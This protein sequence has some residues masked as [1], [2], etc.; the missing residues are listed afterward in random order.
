MNL[1]TLDFETYFD[2]DYTLSK[3]TTEAYVRDPRF[4]VHCVGMQGEYVPGEII[5]YSPQHINRHLTDI[6]GKFSDNALLCHHAQFDGLILSHHY[7]IRPAFWFDTLSMARLVFPHAKSHSLGAL[8]KMLGLPEK[9]VPYESF[10]GLRDLSPDLYNRVAEGC[11]Q[12]VE[13]THSVFKAML[14]FVPMEELRIIDLTI[15]MFTEPALALD[16]PRMQDYLTKTQAEKEA[17]LQTLGVTKSDLQ[18]SEVFAGLLTQCG[19]VPPTKPSPSNPER[20]IYAFAKTDKAMKE[21][22]EHDDERI[23]TL[24]EARLGQKSTIGE[25]RAMRLLD[26]DSRGPLCVYLNYCGAHTLRWSG[27]GG[28]NFQNLPRK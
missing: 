19:V 9:T 10:K 17:L 2:S 6:F 27:G 3:L 28:V 12:D 23:A 7:D 5:T 26:M 21:L 25:T 20:T 16:R 4:K 13:L 8:A 15:R 18:S 14:P 11:I 24:V 1:I 22:L